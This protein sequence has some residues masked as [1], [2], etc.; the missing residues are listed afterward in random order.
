MQYTNDMIL[1]IRHYNEFASNSDIA[2][3]KDE[4]AKIQANKKHRQ[5]RVKWTTTNMSGYYSAYSKRPFVAWLFW[6]YNS[7]S[8]LS[9]IEEYAKSLGLTIRLM[10]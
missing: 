5:I 6:G 7:S 4:L 2:D 10:K 3:M 9:T 1:K 8:K